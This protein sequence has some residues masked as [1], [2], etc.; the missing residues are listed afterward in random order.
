MSARTLL[1]DLHDMPI[2]G[3]MSAARLEK[4]DGVMVKSHFQHSALPPAARQR[5]CAGNAPCN[6]RPV[7][8]RPLRC[9]N[10]EVH[11]LLV[12]FETFVNASEHFLLICQA[13][14]HAEN[15]VA[16]CVPV[17]EEASTAAPKMRRGS[18][19]ARTAR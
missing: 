19:G 16:S 2:A 8:R 4:V 17:E 12:L 9:A 13:L 5:P 7:W 11:Y 10:I 15:M 1:L 6:C 18:S 14:V 3:E